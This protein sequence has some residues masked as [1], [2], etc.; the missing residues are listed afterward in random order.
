MVR[1]I[2]MFGRNGTT[3]LHVLLYYIWD[4][5]NWPEAVVIPC[6]NL[7]SNVSVVTKLVKLKLKL[8]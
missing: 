5:S 2:H 1:K 4:H 8:N 6:H 7:Y 3:V